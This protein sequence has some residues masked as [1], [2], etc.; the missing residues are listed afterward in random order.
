MPQPEDQDLRVCK[1]RGVRVDTRPYPYTIRPGE[2]VIVQEG[3]Y[4]GK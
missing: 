4:K 3:F 2:G 1:A